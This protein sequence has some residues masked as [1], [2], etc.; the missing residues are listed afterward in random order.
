MGRNAG[1]ED[2]YMKVL[3]RHIDLNKTAPTSVEEMKDGEMIMTSDGLYARV[4][5][6][7]L[8]KTLPD[9]AHAIAGIYV[10]NV[11]DQGHI[12]HTQDGSNWTGSG[13][14]FG[15]G[16]VIRVVY[17][18]GGIFLGFT[19][20]DATLCIKS[21]DFGVTWTNLGE[22]NGSTLQ[23][24]YAADYL[25]NGIVLVGDT[26]NAGCYIH[27]STDYGENWTNLGSQFATQTVV[28]IGYAG[29]GVVIAWTGYGA[30]NRYLRSI[31]YGATWED[32]GGVT[33]FSGCFQITHLGDGILIANGTRILKSYDRGLTWEFRGGPAG[34][35]A[36]VYLGDGI[37][38]V[39]TQ[40]DHIW[41][42][43]DYGNSW[44]DMGIPTGPGGP[45]DQINGITHLGQGIVVAGT[46][47]DG[48]MGIS[49][50]Y[51]LTWTT[52][53]E[54]VAGTDWTEWMA[55][56]FPK[57][58]D[59]VADPNIMEFIAGKTADGR[60]TSYQ[61]GGLWST[62]RNAVSG[63]STSNSD[64][65][66]TG[67]T[68]THEPGDEWNVIRSFMYFDLNIP[69]G[70]RI[71]AAELRVHGG[72]ADSTGVSLQQGTQED[73]LTVADFDAFTGP[74][75]DFIASWDMDIWQ[76]FTLS[77]AGVAYLNQVSGAAKFCLREY[78]HDYLDVAPNLTNYY[79]GLYFQEGAHGPYLKLWLEDAPSTTTTTTTTTT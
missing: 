35:D 49:I 74:L 20:W 37:V 28:A 66:Y 42:S 29:N 41:R 36:L 73:P 58:L 16:S 76:T 12:I 40:D 3:S 9:W 25:E 18:G 10:Y 77:G 64:L 19:G 67:M 38:V 51:G 13:Q 32:M 68:A 71:V 22:I 46:Y 62:V 27:R 47:N 65:T 55:T 60:I 4:G 53:L 78:D 54:P 39:G 79:N 5:D 75:F 43:I 48:N 15:Q 57:V 21:T 2:K 56:S 23:E 52:M 6:Q 24:P 14:L 72:V 17:C 70:K 8:S 44:E 26:G 1:L 34:A 63:T 7:V 69:A 45:L 33:G 59:A 61:F 50:D 31:D 30:P 11:S